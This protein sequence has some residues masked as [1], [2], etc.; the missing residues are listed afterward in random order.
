M[1]CIGP[2]E[3]PRQHRVHAL[4]RDPAASLDRE[5]NSHDHRHT[6]SLNRRALMPAVAFMDKSCR[7]PLQ[8][9]VAVLEP[10]GDP[11]ATTAPQ[12]FADHLRH[13]LRNHDIE[14]TE[15]DLIDLAKFTLPRVEMG[16]GGILLDRL[17]IEQQEEV[18]R[19]FDAGDEKPASRIIEEAVPDLVAVVGKHMHETAQAVAASLAQEFARR[20]Q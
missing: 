20:G 11:V 10:D 1:W 9:T 8:M 5:L 6:H 12:T 15:A 3:P 19:C 16:V 14:L 2:I 18:M 7:F 13:A 4:C 17:T